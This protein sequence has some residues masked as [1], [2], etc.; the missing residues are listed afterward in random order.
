[1][2]NHVDN[3]KISLFKRVLSGI[4]NFKIG[5]K[6][7]ALA[8]AVGIGVSLVACVTEQPPADPNQ[9]TVN[10]DQNNNNENDN[11]NNNENNQEPEKEIDYSQFS[12]LLQYVLQD[13]YYNSLIERIKSGEGTNELNDLCSAHP[14]GFYEEQGYDVDTILK[15]EVK[16]RTRSF[17]KEDE[18]NSLYI[19]TIV[20]TKSETPYFTE[21]LIKYELTDKEI[22]EYNLMHKNNYAQ[23]F[24]LN[25]AIS[26]MKDATIV[27]EARCTVK[28]HDGI[29]EALAYQGIAKHYLGADLGMFILTDVN[30]ANN[31]FEVLVIPRTGTFK[32]NQKVVYFPLKGDA[33]SVKLN[34]DNAMFE[35]YHDMGFTYDESKFNDSYIHSADVY[36]SDFLTIFNANCSYIDTLK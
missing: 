18:P 8:L 30:V 21:Y 32:E 4:H 9:G 6:L 23:T 28:A 10:N 16:A 27:S 12:P 15:C 5:K 19:A 11:E 17:F 29:M 34:I 26:R 3:E 13:E 2:N 22:E 31:T 25:D 14:Y 7:A 24:F 20:E 35:P 36:N 33:F 1:M